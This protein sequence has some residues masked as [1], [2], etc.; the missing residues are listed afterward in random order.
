MIVEKFFINELGQRLESTD[1]NRKL[2]LDMKATPNW[3]LI[4]QPKA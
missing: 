4:Y 2:W 1:E 3:R